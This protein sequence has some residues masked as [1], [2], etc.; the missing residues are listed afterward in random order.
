MAKQRMSHQSVV[1]VKAAVK[2]ELIKVDGG[3]IIMLIGKSGKTVKVKSPESEIIYSTVAS[4]DKAI[5]YHNPN[6]TVELKPEI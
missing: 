5:S 4:A 3:Y 1:N 6:L 2:A